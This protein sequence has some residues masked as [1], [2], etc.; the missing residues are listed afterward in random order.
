[1]LQTF[2]D[3]K[4][5]YKE[6]YDSLTVGASWHKPDHYFI[7]RDLPEYVQS[8]LQINEDTKNAQTFAKKRMKNVASSAYFSSDRTVRGYAAEIWGV[9][10]EK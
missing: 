1:M 4:G 9:S 8:L 10:D 5:Y 2:P 6:L 3:E 7:F